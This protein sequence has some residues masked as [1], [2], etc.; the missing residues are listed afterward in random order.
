MSPSFFKN[1]GPF[2]AESIF[3]TIDCKHLNIEKNHT[4]KELVGIFKKS[5]NSISFIYDNENNNFTPSKDT[6]I[7]CSKKKVNN[8]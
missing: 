3:A 2:S 6:A 7:V 8:I 5:K 4:F 1:L